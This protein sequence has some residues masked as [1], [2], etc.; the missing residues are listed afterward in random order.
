MIITNKVI[1]ASLCQLIM[2]YLEPMCSDPANALFVIDNKF[3]VTAQKRRLIRNHLNKVIKNMI[4][5]EDNIEI[6][7]VVN[8]IEDRPVITFKQ[9]ADIDN[10]KNKISSFF[11]SRK[12]DYKR[13][14]LYNADSSLK[15]AIKQ[16]TAKQ[17]NKSNFL[18]VITQSKMKPAD[19]T[20]VKT[21]RY[22]NVLITVIANRQGQTSRSRALATQRKY[23]KPVFNK[24]QFLTAGDQVKEILCHEYPYVPE[25]PE[26]CRNID[27]FFVIMMDATL[28]DNGNLNFKEELEEL[29]AD[30]DIGSASDIK[31]VTYGNRVQTNVAFGVINS[32]EDIERE[33]ENLRHTGVKNN[34]LPSTSLKEVFDTIVE[35]LKGSNKPKYI[36][37]FVNQS[38]RDLD[39]EEF[40]NEM[41]DSKINVLN[42]GQLE[43]V[44]IEKSILQ[45]TTLLTENREDDVPAYDESIAEIVCNI[46]TSI[47]M[48]TTAAYTTTG[49]YQTTAPVICKIESDVIFILD[50]ESLKDSTKSDDVMV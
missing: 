33:V 1:S 48:A 22:E 7:L 44:W 30:I 4:L 31:F 39:I 5:G 41:Q 28:F 2:I 25:E 6:S 26:K 29:L 18:F 9:G 8:G 38:Y 17:N 42:V 15:Y 21:L 23:Y 11:S 47:Y 13:T 37:N 36:I 10:V 3:L 34:I 27:A 19:P 16:F 45:N 14:N 20:L 35:E 40:R 43:S 32:E 12:N 49:P 24:N 46:Q 50:K